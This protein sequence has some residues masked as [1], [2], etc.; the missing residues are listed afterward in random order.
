MDRDLI[1]E[2][3]GSSSS[4]REEIDTEILVERIIDGFSVARNFASPLEQDIILLEINDYF[5]RKSEANQWM[6][7][8][9]LPQWVSIIINKISQMFVG[10]DD[11]AENYEYPLMVA[12]LDPKSTKNFTRRGEQSIEAFGL[13]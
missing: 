2:L 1:H 6:E 9:S 10:L 8:G 3:F 11:V 13:T 12:G 4:S 7:F 5:K